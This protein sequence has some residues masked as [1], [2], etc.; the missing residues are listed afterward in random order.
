[1]TVNSPKPLD[2]DDE[3]EGE[4]KDCLKI[5]CRNH[6]EKKQW[7]NIPENDLEKVK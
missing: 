5:I 6:K 2:K 1:M 3:Y 7:Q 4:K